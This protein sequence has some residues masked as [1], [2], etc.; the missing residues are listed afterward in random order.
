MPL[1]SEYEEWHKEAALAE[2]TACCL[3]NVDI[4]VDHTPRLWMCRCDWS[5]R[6]G[7]TH[8]SG[9]ATNYRYCPRCKDRDIRLVENE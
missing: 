9:G 1:D 2:Y 5:G 8:N 7:Q 4:L 3:P 6:P